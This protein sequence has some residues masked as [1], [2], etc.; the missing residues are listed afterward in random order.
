MFCR[1]KMI[2]HHNAQTGIVIYTHAFINYHPNMTHLSVFD[3]MISLDRLNTITACVFLNV[4]LA[5][6]LTSH[7]CNASAE[8]T[9]DQSERNSE[10]LNGIYIL[11][12]CLILTEYS[13]IFSPRLHSCRTQMHWMPLQCRHSL[14]FSL[15][16]PHNLHTCIWEKGIKWAIRYE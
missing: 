16:L 12:I 4:P 11:K 9:T 8:H 1:Q 6:P 2:A 13:P 3:D 14:W 15:A 7:T 5:A 10:F